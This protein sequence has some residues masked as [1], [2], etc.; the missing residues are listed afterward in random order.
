MKILNIIPKHL[1]K[2][3]IGMIFLFLTAIIGVINQKLII[4]N[5]GSSSLEFYI[6]TLSWFFQLSMIFTFGSRTAFIT[7]RKD[8][9]NLKKYFLSSLFFGILVSSSIGLLASIFL[10]NI[11]SLPTG[12]TNYNLSITLFFV[13]QTI[14]LFF[15]YFLIAIEKPTMSYALFLTSTI[16]STFFLKFNFFE[17]IIFLYSISFLLV[18]FM[19]IILLLREV[20][21]SL[22]FNFF[23]IFQKNFIYARPFIFSEMIDVAAERGGI[24]FLAYIAND[25]SGMAEYNIAL[26]IAGISS[27]GIN[28][29]NQVFS[30]QLYDSINMDKK[31]ISDLY[32]KMRNYSV[33][34]S[35]IAF[36]FILLIGKN[37]ILYFFTEKYIYAFNLLLIL[38]LGQLIHSSFGPNSLLGHLAGFTI[39]VSTYK[40]ITTILMVFMSYLFFEK[41]GIDIVAY[42]Y[43]LSLFLWNLIVRIKIRSLIF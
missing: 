28:V 5:Y 30:P 11:D 41:V 12:T 17:D 2:S 26:T 32:I 16:L 37:F 23:K 43:V 8:I 31:I 15:S 19:Y 10:F 14:M 33:L 29:I 7:L 38:Q 27:V 6:L 42:S 3:V 18:I 1:A 24:F 21:L 34:F 9:N 35:L 20:N 22:N 36:L 25:L 40:L 4:Q 13:A 39:N